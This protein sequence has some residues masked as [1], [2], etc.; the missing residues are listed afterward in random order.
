MAGRVPARRARSGRKARSTSSLTETYSCSDS[1]S[2]SP[3]ASANLECKGRPF[4]LVVDLIGTGIWRHVD[5]LHV[6]LT[7]VLETD[8]RD[9]FGIG[10]HA[11]LLKSSLIPESPS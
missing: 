7:R 10:A 6:P 3:R 8:S 2:E 5:E 1:T 4:R 9:S 11:S